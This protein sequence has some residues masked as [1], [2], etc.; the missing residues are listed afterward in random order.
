[1]SPRNVKSLIE[2]IVNSED[3]TSPLNDREKAEFL[4]MQGIHISRR[5]VAKYK[6][7]LEIPTVDRRKRYL[8]IR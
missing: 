7:E 1:M 6:S 5:T 4:N 8:S 2:E 3:K